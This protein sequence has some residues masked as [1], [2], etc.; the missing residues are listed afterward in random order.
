M[1]LKVKKGH[2]PKPDKS[3]STSHGNSCSSLKKKNRVVKRRFA[4]WKHV[5]FLLLTVKKIDIQD[6][7]S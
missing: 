6:N 2:A 1:I 5:L 3:A 4:G 7:E